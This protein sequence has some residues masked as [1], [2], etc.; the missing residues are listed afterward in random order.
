MPEKVVCRPFGIYTGREHEVTF[1]VKYSG[2]YMYPMQAIVFL[3]GQ[4]IEGFEGQPEWVMRMLDAVLYNDGILMDR[5][6]PAPDDY[7]A[8]AGP[9]DPDGYSAPG[10]G[11]FD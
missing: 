11:F 8:A 2:D 4:M 6:D 5:D 1:R 7:G 9:D 3:A 10:D